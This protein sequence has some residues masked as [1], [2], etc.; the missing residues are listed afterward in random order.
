MNHAF[1]LS[2]IFPYC[3]NTPV[4]TLIQHLSWSVV[5]L[6][7]GYIFVLA[8][9]ALSLCSV[10]ANFFGFGSRTTIIG[11]VPELVIG[12]LV[13]FPVGVLAALFHSCTV[14]VSWFW[15]GFR[16]ATLFGVLSVCVL[17]LLGLSF[18]GG[19]HQVHDSLVG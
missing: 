17:L 3:F 15:F 1:P 19:L 9:S 10:Y 7:I 13:L 18:P 14:G 8:F 11:F 2:L 6:G 16:T 4:G 12:A 5:R